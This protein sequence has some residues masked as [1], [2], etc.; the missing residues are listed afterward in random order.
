MPAEYGE[1][2]PIVAG[3]LI[4]V[5]G[6]PIEGAIIHAVLIEA[7]GGDNWHSSTR[8]DTVRERNRF[9]TDRYGEYTGRLTFDDST[10]DR[11]AK[12]AVF[13]Y[14]CKEGFQPFVLLRSKRGTVVVRRTTDTRQAAA[15]SDYADAMRTGGCQ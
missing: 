7:S 13:Y 12:K 6:N 9:T 2:H 10:L 14:S 1:K 4:D 3:R 15:P 8:W 5:D 11:S